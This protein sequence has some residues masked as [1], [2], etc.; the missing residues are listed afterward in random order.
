MNPRDL[1]PI[2]TGVQMRRIDTRAIDGMGIPSLTLMEN[3]GTGIAQRI[4]E[5]IIDGD[6]RGKRIA[7]ICGPGNNGGDGFV[8]ARHLAGNGA[9]VSVYLIGPASA[10][11][12]DGLANAKRAASSVLTTHEILSES[13]LPV[14]DKCD[15]IV[16]AIYGTGFHGSV[17]GIAARII[18]AING[19]GVPVAA[20]DTPSGLNSETGA[21]SDPT[22]KA[23]GTFALAAS[24]RG[25]WLWPGRGF[26][27]DLETIDIGIP[28][29]AFAHEDIRLRLITDEFVRASLP[30]RPPDAYKGT[31]GKALI[32]GGSTGMSGAVVLAANACLRAGVGLVYAGVPQSL[33]DVVDGGSIETVV[34]P[35]PEVRGPRVLARRGL[36]EI[37]KLWESADAV[38]IGPGLSTHFETQ[39][40]VRRLI[41][42]RKKPTVL[43]ADG[44]NACAKEI[45]VLKAGGDVPLVIT[46]HA[47]EMAR[48]LDQP[49]AEINADREAAARTAAARFGCIVV[50][51]GAPTFVADQA[52]DVYLNPTGNSGMAT[53][54]VGDVLTGMIVSFLAQGAEPLTAA[55]C[56]VYLH[57]AAGDFAASDLSERA[58]VASDLLTALPSVFQTL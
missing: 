53:G 10:L 28:P 7:V 1:P 3:A 57:G 40:L 23:T 56:A 14:L 35:L 34:R 54:G 51:K 29:E 42:R 26:I 52:G 15:L 58:L 27:G 8:V 31:F 43:D 9:A 45:A 55:M 24:K 32:I 50:M 39:D 13:D 41:G 19:S 30:V 17:S 25:Q 22:T 6:V 33:V 12:G 18:E 16:D 5:T 47:G 37:V 20:V 4:R 36:G 46:P 21:V 11:T 48:L 38:A 49:L 44:L 2:V